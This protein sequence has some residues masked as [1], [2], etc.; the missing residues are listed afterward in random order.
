[1]ENVLKT[2]EKTREKIRVVCME[3]TAAT[4]Q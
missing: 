4:E 3:R 2:R 1:V